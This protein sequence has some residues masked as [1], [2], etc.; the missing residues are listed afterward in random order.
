MPINDNVINQEQFDKYFSK[1]FIDKDGKNILKTTVKDGVE[2]Y[3]L[4]SLA[5]CRRLYE[6]HVGHKI[7][8]PNKSSDWKKS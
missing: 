3:V 1:F 7:D 6:I 2:Y 8:W 4:P 5:E